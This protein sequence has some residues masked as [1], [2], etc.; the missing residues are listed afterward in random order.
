MIYVDDKS[1]LIPQAIS[2]PI[3]LLNLPEI[4]KKLIKV[5]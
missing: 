3:S 5:C 2:Q 1:D 4:V